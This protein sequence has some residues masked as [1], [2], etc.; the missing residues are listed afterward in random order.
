MEII[1]VGCQSRQ[2]AL[3][4]KITSPTIAIPAPSA[5][6]AAT[7]AAAPPAAEQEFMNFMKETPSQQYEDLWLQQHGLTKQSLA[8]MSPEDQKKIMDKMKQDIEQKIKDA[9]KKQDQRV[10]ILT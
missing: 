4:Q 9:M 5:D 10:N 1:T 3:R 6:A 2:S 8:A 7:I